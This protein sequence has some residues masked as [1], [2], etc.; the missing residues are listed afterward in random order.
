MSKSKDKK[1]S[2]Q[3]IL[4]V[5]KHEKDA[6]I[7]KCKA[8]DSSAARELRRF[9]REFVATDPA[10]VAPDREAVAEADPAEADPAEA[11]PA[12]ADPAEAGPAEANAA[13]ANL[14]E[15]NLPEP[16]LPEPSLPEAG[17]AEA[18]VIGEDVAKPKKKAKKK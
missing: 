17:L 10:K 18:V 6:F 14:P 11:D 15:P 8:L 3:M 4:R 16:N 13:E 7:D 1:K 2:S 12:E 9:M 5:E